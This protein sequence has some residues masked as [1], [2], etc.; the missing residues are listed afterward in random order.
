MVLPFIFV[1]ISPD[2]KPPLKEKK[3]TVGPLHKSHFGDRTKWPLWRGL[4]KIQWNLMDS[5]PQKSG[6]C[7]KV[8]VV[9][10]WPLLEVGLYL[11]KGVVCDS[12]FNLWSG[13]D[14]KLWDQLYVSTFE[15]CLSYTVNSLITVNFWVPL[16]RC[17]KMRVGV[18]PLIWKSFFILMQIRLISTRKFVHLASFWKWGFLELGS[19]LLKEVQKKT[20]GPALC[21]HLWEKPVL[22]KRVQKGRNQLEASIACF[23]TEEDALNYSDA[24]P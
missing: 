7:R 16:G 12:F 14:K 8:A 20:L 11:P 4:H 15:S 19:G 10:K 24:L 17:F 22:L 1:I 6:H 21:V 3:H 18:Q 2:R 5:P 9:E 23:L 13:L